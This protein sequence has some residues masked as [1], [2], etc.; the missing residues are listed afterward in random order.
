MLDLII[1]FSPPLY[2]GLAF[3]G[4]KYE[5]GEGVCCILET[6]FTAFRMICVFFYVY[7]STIYQKKKAA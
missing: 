5:K 2:E 1:I 4:G 3:W 7:E 6:H